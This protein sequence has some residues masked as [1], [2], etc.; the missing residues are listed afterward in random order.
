MDY[1]LIVVGAGNAG[2]AAA[3]VA[4]EAGWSVAVVERRDVGGTCPLRGCVP[5][6]VLVAAAEALDQIARADAHRIAVGAATL[7]WP[8]LM[9]RKQTFV[10]G[11]PA[12][13]ERSLAARGID[14]LRGAARFVGRDAVD[15]DGRRFRARKFVVAVGSVPRRLPFD[16]AD[17]VI[18]SD[19]L[20]ELRERPASLAFV[21]AGVIAFEF[22]HVLARA[23]TKVTLLELLPRPLARLDADAVDALVAVTR[24]LGVDVLTG[25]SVRAVERDGAAL[26][27]HYTTEG[28]NGG[29]A[30]TLRVDCVANGGGRVADLAGLALDA[31]GVGLRDGRPAL[32]AYLR[33]VENPDVYFAGDANPTAPQLS[34]VATYEGGIV[35]RNLVGEAPQYTPDYRPI[36]SAVFAIPALATVGLTEDAARREGLAYEARAHDMRD[37]R[38]TRTYAERVA[39]AKVLVE[40]ETDRILGAHLLG[41]GAAETIHAF[42]L[43]IRHGLKSADLRETVYA[44]PTFHSDI[45]YLL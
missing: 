5:K 27:V 16:G 17:Q 38:S 21:G 15:V 9:A 34:P 43:A 1:D 30:A 42:A 31:A 7:D 4:R 19:A 12:E 35:G 41:H 29:E 13:L 20:L 3:G 36:P 45:R 23:G 40:R 6:K 10:A 11:V 25:V 24:S 2:L 28:A 39:Y 14:L 33:S 44:Y 37:W 18:T 8:A 26:A 32:D 22:A